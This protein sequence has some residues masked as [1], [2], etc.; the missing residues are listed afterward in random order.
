DDRSIPWT[1]EQA[2]SITVH[3]RIPEQNKHYT[4]SDNISI[5]V[6]EWSM[7]MKFDEL[8]D[9][10]KGF[11]NVNGTMIVELKVLD[12]MTSCWL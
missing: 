12:Q 2:S 1:I 4:N 9:E 3:N 7:Y 6:P 10:Q 5:D 8:M 11:K